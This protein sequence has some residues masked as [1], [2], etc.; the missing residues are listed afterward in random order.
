MIGKAVYSLL[1]VSAVTDLT[2]DISPN[3]ASRNATM[4]YIVFNEDGTPEHYKDAYGIVYYQLQIDIYA[5]QT[6]EGGGGKAACLDIS[7]QVEIILS[8][9]KGTV[10]GVVIEN[11]VLQNK[12]S[13]FD[14]IA[15]AERVMLTY[16][17]RVKESAPILAD[18]V[19]Y[20]VIGTTF[21]VQ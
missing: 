13:L 5:E 1:N 2:N 17:V 15:E 10:E 20:W 19:G 18:G 12:E 21:I 9:Y 3:Q 11:T 16:R 14:P 6:N 8:R 4:P 7:E